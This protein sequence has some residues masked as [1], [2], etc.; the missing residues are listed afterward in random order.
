ME[1]TSGD[2]SQ[3]RGVNRDGIPTPPQTVEPASPTPAVSEPPTMTTEREAEIREW[4]YA[5]D[6]E[7]PGVV[8]ACRLVVELDAERRAHAETQRKLAEAQRELDGLRA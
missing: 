2:K 4:G 1:A 6:P 3:D 7:L 8:T 5:S